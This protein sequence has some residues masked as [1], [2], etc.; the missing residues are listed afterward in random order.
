MTSSDK[1]CSLNIELF[2]IRLVLFGWVFIA[3]TTASQLINYFLF[4][5]L[6][7]KWKQPFNNVTNQNALST[8][9]QGIHIEKQ[10][11]C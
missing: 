7:A 10:S 9:S 6:F 4:E 2:E 5:D 1:F 11:N 3:L 8:W